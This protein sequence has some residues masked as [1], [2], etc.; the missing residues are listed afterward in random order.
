M[1]FYVAHD[2]FI[3]PVRKEFVGR[4]AGR[5]RRTRLPRLLT[6]AAG[7][8]EPAPQL[9]LADR[10]EDLCSLQRPGKL[11][12]PP[13]PRSV[14]L[15]SFSTPLQLPDNLA[16][17]TPPPDPA[18][19]CHRL[20][21]AREVV[22]QAASITQWE[23]AQEYEEQE[24]SK[25]VAR[26]GWEAG[27]QGGGVALTSVTS[28]L[29]A[30]AD[31]T[32]ETWEGIVSSC[33]VI[34][35]EC[36]VNSSVQTADI[37]P[38]L[39]AAAAESSDEN[40]NEKFETIDN[41]G[42]GSEQTTSQARCSLAV[43]DGDESIVSEDEI[44]FDVTR[45]CGESEEP[46]ISEGKS[47]SSEEETNYSEEEE[48]S[49]DSLP[50]LETVLGCGSQQ[51]ELELYPEMWRTQAGGAGRSR[52]RFLLEADRGERL[53]SK[54]LPVNIFIERNFEQ[55]ILLNCQQ[56]VP[57]MDIDGLLAGVQQVAGGGGEEVALL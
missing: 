45:V 52:S 17:Q 2:S 25:G 33:S 22:M 44:S 15:T 3:R 9:E 27:L 57:C 55:Q 51:P 32:T 26:A 39:T 16:P 40:N 49:E 8:I 4:G 5:W 54:A 19:A 28:P 30:A 23:R 41:Q 36:I 14:S 35:L 42:S 11:E 34:S 1:A 18:R 43:T 7:D 47:S 12:T 29:Q 46:S 53:V 31:L 37:C 24:W 48:S 6:A 13:A 56:S 10:L 50:D 38:H 20:L 21:G